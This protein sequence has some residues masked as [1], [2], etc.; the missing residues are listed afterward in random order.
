MGELELVLD[1]KSVLGEGP[2]WDA[3]RQCLY[4]VDIEGR[5]IHIYD[6]KSGSDREIE[7]PQRVGAVVPRA[8]GGL[9][10]ALHDGFYAVDPDTGAVQPLVRSAEATEDVRFN[11]GKCDAAGRFLAG[12]MSISGVPQSGI[13][14]SL[15]TDLSVHKMVEQVTTSNGIAWSPDHKTMYYIDSPT[16]QIV[17]YDYDLDSGTIRNGRAVIR[18]PDGQ[19]VPDGMTSDTEG[20]LWIAQ[21]G[22][23]RVT[24]WNPHN[25]ECIATVS[26]PAARVTSC[27]FAGDDLSELYITTASVGL[28]DEQRKEQPHA[29]GLFRIKTNVRGMP[30]FAFEG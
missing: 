1:A 7:V 27:V 13:L 2:S 26:V 11:D 6:P 24:R 21:W 20:M 14:Y 9:V 5:K 16:K 30:T 10:A 23:Y 29:G 22:G 19:G 25:G 18:I 17:A 15:H 4:W 8:S 3:R 12:T 28:T